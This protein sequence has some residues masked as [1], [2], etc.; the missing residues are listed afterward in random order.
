[1]KMLKRT[2][3]LTVLLMASGLFAKP[4]CI[5]PTEALH[6]MNRTYAFEGAFVWTKGE[7]K[8]I[9]RSTGASIYRVEV[10]E[11]FASYGPARGPHG[12]FR[13]DVV[14]LAPFLVEGTNRV[15]FTVVGYQVNSYYLSDLPPFLRAEV[16]VGERTLWETS[17]QTVVFRDDSRVQKVSRYSF[18]RPF[19][20][21][22]RMGNSAPRVRVTDLTVRPDVRLFPRRA[23][24]PTFAVRRDIR[25]YA[26]GVAGLKNGAV[27]SD[28]CI[29]LASPD[30]WMK[31][32]QKSDLEV[33]LVD[34]F[35]RVEYRE[36][37]PFETSA[38][39]FRLKAGEQIH[40]AA[41]CVNTGF[42]GMDVRASAGSSVWATFD[43]ILVDGVIDPMRGPCGNL[44]RWDFAVEGAYALETFEPYC[45]KY[46]TL[47]AFGGDVEISAPF[48]RE[49]VHP[50]AIVPDDRIEPRFHEIDLAA[51]RTYA[52]NAVDA[53]TDCPS[54]ERAGWL[55]DSFWMARAAESL[56]G[57][58]TMEDL[59]LENYALAEKFPSIE[60]GMAPMC[61]PADH[62]DGNFIPNWAMWLILQLEEYR[63]VRAGDPQLV[64]KLRPRVLGLVDWFARH[65]NEEGLLEKMPGWNFIEWSRAN[66]FVQDVNFP[67]N[68][69][70][71]ATLEAVERLYGVQGLKEKAARLRTII[72]RLSFDGRYYRDHAVRKDGQLVVVQEDISETCQ[73]YAFFFGTATPE[74]RPGLWR[75]ILHDFGPL[76][77]EE[78]R[79]VAVAPSNA[80][81]GHFLRLDL[82]RRYGERDAMLKEIGAYFGK[83]ATATGTL[84]EHDS[85]KASCCHGFASYVHT[86]LL[87]PDETHVL[88]ARIDALAASGGGELVIGPGVHR[89]GALFF[90]PGVNLRIEKGG[91]LVESDAA[92]AYPIRETRIEGETCDYYPALINADRCDGFRIS[93]EG[94]VD[95][96]GLPTW[97]AFWKA[98]EANP[99]CLNKEPG[100]VRPRLL[101]VSNSADVDVSGVTFK[102]SKFWTTH[103]YNCRNVRVRDCAIRAEILEGVKGPSTDAIDIDRCQG[104]VVSNVVMDVNDDAVVIKGGKGPWANDPSRHPENGPSVG[105]EVVDSVFGSS[106]HSC[107]TLG[108]ECPAASNVVVR[109]CRVEGAGNLLCLKMRTDTPQRFSDIRVEGCVGSCGT[110]LR[111]PAWRQFANLGDRTPADVFSRAT[112][113]TFVRNALA[114][115]QVA[116]KD[117]AEGIYELSDVTFDGNR[118][119]TPDMM[120]AA[121]FVRPAR[122]FDVR[123]Y[124]SVAY[125]GVECF[126]YSPLV[127]A[128]GATNVAVTGSGTLRAEHAFWYAWNWHNPESRQGLDDLTYVWAVA[129]RPVEAR[130]MTKVPGCRLRPQFLHF[131]RCRNVRIEGVRIRESPF[132]C[133]HTYAC[134][135]VVVRGVDVCAH[136][137]NSDGIDLEMTKNALVEGCT[138]CQGDD[139]ICV[140]AGRNADGRRV[141]ICSENIEIRNCEIRAGHQLLALGSEL[142]AGIR[143]VWLHDCRMTGA[144]CNGLLVKTNA[145]RGGFV[146]DVRFERVT[147]AHLEG[148]P[149][150]IRTT[151]FVQPRPGIETV[152]TRIR[153]IRVQDVMAD[154]AACA[155]SLMGDPACPVEG[156]T[157]ENVVVRAATGTNVVEHV[158]GFRCQQGR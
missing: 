9:L 42:F 16:S 17:A 39:S 102:N 82:L 8:P 142:S 150:A 129:G 125:E 78:R 70:Y 143:N 20:E 38:T 51:K 154:E 96:H 145:E 11:R 31:G 107:L 123:D 105:V 47:T 27:K 5:W 85:P 79:D 130:D 110:V 49:Y 68:M 91:I 19:G 59:F 71:A 22:Y 141:G 72:N 23:P 134:D 111:V 146:E 28:R 104:F 55:C 69:A 56:T 83:M 147:A 65:E 62:A 15:V 50:L 140:K 7:A 118:F 115:R 73:Y 119:E 58:R 37:K 120:K 138:F 108:S 149:V 76:V 29:D 117:A 127:Y 97:R 137:H 89:A 2:L 135:G 132:W 116:R 36:V 75:K 34:D 21:V 106:C 158:K 81:I 45:F 95:G 113:V 6:E 63:F 98:R 103:F 33:N 40:F 4:A 13:E 66:E 112:G 94:V 88:Q 136:I 126:N 64:E 121:V 128:Y 18:Q 114:C 1:M 35:R 77:A 67:A 133:I 99:R 80:F 43:E 74:S 156:V 157:L 61:Y 139:A 84:W 46:L 26:R 87:P 153:N 48:L 24:M 155:Y 92:A 86:L 148:A 152:R 144:T 93:G 109:N 100:L 151:Y 41:P 101:Y 30:G 54:R 90:R 52:Q 14:D 124:P 25:P 3:L 122:T 57:D 12:Y 44:V 10:N 131:N 32:F 60:A 53:F